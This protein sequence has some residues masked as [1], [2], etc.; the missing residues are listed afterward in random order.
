MNKLLVLISFFLIALNAPS[1]RSQN[2]DCMLKKFAIYNL[3]A[4]TQLVEWMLGATEQQFTQDVESSFSSLKKTTAHIWNAEYG[5]L[6]Y[7][8]EKTWASPANDFE[9]ATMLNFLKKFEEHSSLLSNFVLNLD[10]KGFEKIYTSSDGS[11]TTAQDIIL[12]V[13][14]HSTFHRGQIIT[15]ARQLGLK[16]APRTDF[17]YYSK[18]RS[19]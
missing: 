3:W 19:E 2:S 1:L 16:N 14:N 8:E 11:A 13:F 18:M 9:S 4:N 6:Q 7:L 17:I 10:E 15:I 5:W 12:H